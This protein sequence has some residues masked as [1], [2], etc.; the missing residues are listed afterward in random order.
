[1]PP[2]EP[3]SRASRYARAS[4]CSTVEP[5]PSRVRDHV[6]VGIHPARF[7]AR[8]T[9]QRQELAATA[10]DVEHRRRVAEVVHVHA[11]PLPNGRGRAAHSRLE[12]EVVRDGGS[13]R[14]CRDRRHR[15]GSRPAAAPFDAPQAF[16]QLDERA[17][18]RLVTRHRQIERLVEAVDKL[19]HRVVESSLLGCERLDVPAQ[20]RPQQSLDRIR[21]RALDAWA[22]LE[23][24]LRRNRPHALGLGAPGR[25][26]ALCTGPAAPNLLA[27]LLEQRDGV[28][29]RRQRG[30]CRR[31]IVHAAV[32]HLQ[33]VALVCYGIVSGRRG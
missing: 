31:T 2:S 3:S 13:G 7:D 27:E 8:F 9:Q 22:T 4:A 1:M 15:R 33:I 30:L 21:D 32:R 26:S 17:A 19:E 10:A 18:T 25:A 6:S 28:D 5:L 12:P 14:L 23:R 24:P 11:L 20:E 29:L 16:L